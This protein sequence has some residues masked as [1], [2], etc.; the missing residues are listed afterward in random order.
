MFFVCCVLLTVAGD[1]EMNPNF[2]QDSFES[3][4]SKG[5]ACP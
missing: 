1:V 3:E 4:G 5:T 2:I